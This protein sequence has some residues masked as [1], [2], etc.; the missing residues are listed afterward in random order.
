[1]WCCSRMLHLNV[2]FLKNAAASSTAPSLLMQQSC[3]Q[4]WCVTQN[5]M[6]K[7]IH[8]CSA[9]VRVWHVH[10]VQVSQSL[11]IVTEFSDDFGLHSLRTSCCGH[12]EG[13]EV[14]HLLPLVHM[15]PHNFSADQLT[16]A[17]SLH[18]QRVIHTTTIFYWV[19]AE[20]LACTLMELH[21]PGDHIH[22][23]PVCCTLY[24]F[25]ALYVAVHLQMP[26]CFCK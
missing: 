11:L 5:I 3:S 14:S 10:A 24:R 16:M 12:C 9:E 22:S 6:Y 13:F 21:W 1:M 20:P 15:G 25:H 2:A 8:T 18:S 17:V 23:H 19:V 4:F 7:S 26:L